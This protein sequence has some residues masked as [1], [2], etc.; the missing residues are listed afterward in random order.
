MTTAAIADVL[1]VTAAAFVT[2]ELAV[3]ANYVALRWILRAMDAGLKKT[4][5]AGQ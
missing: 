2:F 4:E 3:A 1:W 5:S